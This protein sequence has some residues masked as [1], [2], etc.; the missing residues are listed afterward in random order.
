MT[1]PNNAAA[2]GDLLGDATP[3][4]QPAPAAPSGPYRDDDGAP[5][6]RLSPTAL[7]T[8]RRE[9]AEIWDRR[10]ASARF[11]KEDAAL[12]TPEA[13]AAYL[14]SFD[15]ACAVDGMQPSADGPSEAERHLHEQHLHALFPD[16]NNYNPDMG[17]LVRTLPADRLNVA[18]TELQAFAASME[19]D[20]ALGNAVT[21]HIASEGPRLAAMSESAKLQWMQQ[22]VRMAGGA[23][24]L[25]ALSA[26]AKTILGVSGGKN[27]IATDLSNTASLMNDFWLVSTL[28]NFAKARE[29]FLARGK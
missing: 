8:E 21:S 4:V 14:K 22:Q 12:Y 18:R 5:R 24:R 2:V 16:A 26:Q 3:P 10:A 25:A 17:D 27:A 7:A 15:D 13:R 19:F 23:E 1:D 20:S 6:A 9:Y 11:N 28:T 29:A